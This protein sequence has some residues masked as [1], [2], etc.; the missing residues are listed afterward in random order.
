MDR[1]LNTFCV[2]VFNLKSLKTAFGEWADVSFR[3]N[4]AIL[5]LICNVGKSSRIM[6]KVTILGFQFVE[7]KSFCHTG[8]ALVLNSMEA[9]PY[10]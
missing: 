7:Q 10:L 4:L 9:N 1:A 6:E 8:A 3:G 2:C 5:S